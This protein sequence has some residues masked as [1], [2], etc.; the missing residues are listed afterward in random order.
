MSIDATLSVCNVI[1]KYEICTIGANCKQVKNKH[2]VYL[3]I[4]IVKRRVKVVLDT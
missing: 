4:Y 3:L 1:W 2:P